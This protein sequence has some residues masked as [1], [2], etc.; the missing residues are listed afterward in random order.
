VDYGY[1]YHYAYRP[2]VVVVL[3]LGSYFLVVDG[4]DDLVA[5]T[6]VTDYIETCID[7][8]FEGWDGDTVF[9]L[10]NGQTWQQKRFSYRYHYAYRPEVLIYWDGSEYLMRV[11]GMDDTIAVVRIL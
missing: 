4:V 6:Q 9:P 3:Y 7:G 8:A 11:E 1:V 2:N 5:V 10:C